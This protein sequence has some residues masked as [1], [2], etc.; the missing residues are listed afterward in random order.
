MSMQMDEQ[1]AP[2]NA[3]DEISDLFAGANEQPPAERDAWLE[4][5]CAGR[6]ALR[7]EVAAMLR[8]DTADARLAIEEQLLSDGDPTFAEGVELG[9]YRIRRW[10][11]RGGMGDV[12]LGE[13]SGDQLAAIK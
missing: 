4:R 2:L 8:A 10:L 5:A 12:Y 1:Q 9:G 3:W 13:R 11:G 6:A 7:D